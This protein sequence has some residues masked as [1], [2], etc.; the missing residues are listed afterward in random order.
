MVHSL[1]NKNEKVRE[2][3]LHNLLNIMVSTFYYNEIT[4]TNTEFK[5]I[6]AKWRINHQQRDIIRS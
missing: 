4:R 2:S 3:T 6:F 5:E 1:A